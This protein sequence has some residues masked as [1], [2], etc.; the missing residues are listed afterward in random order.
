M[1]RAAQLLL[2][3]LAAGLLGLRLLFPDCFDDRSRALLG[4]IAGGAL[5]L[6]IIASGLM[7]AG[8]ARMLLPEQP[9]AETMGAALTTWIGRVL[10]AQALCAAL[11][12]AS[13]AIAGWP[14]VA[15]GLA[16]AAATGGALRGHVIASGDG[17]A[18]DIA[19]VLH[20]TLASLWI[21]G[22]GALVACRA[23]EV[24]GRF[25]GRWRDVLQAFSPWALRGMV[26]LLATGLLLADRTVASGAALL[27][28]PYG[29]WLLAKLGFIVAALFCAGRLRRWLP[30]G[31]CWR[32]PCACSSSRRQW[33][34]RPPFPP[35]TT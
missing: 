25:G 34:S 32:A 3:A 35:P 22:L 1:L 30:H 24:R 10:A 5:A 21:A 13:L 19:A 26:L 14:R 16:L 28:T 7:L 9:L 29:H 6:C 8:H 15:T 11:A 18:L 33:R 2:P 23:L 20:L 17:G 12:L 4:R 27:A 31:W